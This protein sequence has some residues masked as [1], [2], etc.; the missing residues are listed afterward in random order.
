LCDVTR[1]IPHYPAGPLPLP[2]FG[3]VPPSTY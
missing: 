3:H 1:F 2:L